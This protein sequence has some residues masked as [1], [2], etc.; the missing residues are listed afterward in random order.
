MKNLINGQKPE[1]GN[2]EQIKILQKEQQKIQD[3]K[4]SKDF[5]KNLP[6]LAKYIDD[7]ASIDWIFM[8]IDLKKEEIKKKLNGRDPITTMIDKVTGYEKGLIKS[9]L[10]DLK[11]GYIELVKLFKRVDEKE[12]YEQYQKLLDAVKLGLKTEYKNVKAVQINPTEA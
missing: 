2:L 10:L 5:Y 3:E 11:E 1:F 7:L 9:F 8:V 12:Q 6:P 4:D